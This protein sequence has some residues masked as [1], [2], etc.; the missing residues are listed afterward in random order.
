MDE[1][2]SG[3]TIAWDATSEEYL[4]RWNRLISTTNW[5]KGRIILEWRAALIDAGASASDYSDET[6]SQQVGAVSPQH[7]G[8]LR[9]VAE[10]FAAVRDDF[11]G[12]YWSHFQAALDWNDA[13]MWLEGAVQ[14]DWSVSQMRRQRWEA[15]GAPAEMKPR[16]EDIVSSE[17]DE[18]YAAAPSAAETAIYPTTETLSNDDG[19]DEAREA[20]ERSSRAEYESGTTE[21]PFDDS[22]D[23]EAREQGEPATA[24]VRPFESLAELPDDLADALESFKLAILRHKTAG[25]AEVSPD[26][27]LA[28]LAA[29]RE[30][31]LAP[32]G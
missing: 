24:T 31:V 1:R 2:T 27:V 16:E 11:Q 32:A 7:V 22:F 15:I 20:V 14:N 29:L 3:E 25:W 8:R 13:E 30:L 21:A 18:D 23:P 5:E 17:V 12:L 6:W 28:S 26:D 10:R 4:G 9:R 19:N